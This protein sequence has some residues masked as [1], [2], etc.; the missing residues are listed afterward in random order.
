MMNFAIIKNNVVLNVIDATHRNAQLIAQT[1]EGASFFNVDGLPVQSGDDYIDGEFYRG[2]LNITG[3]IKASRFL[4][5]ND[6][7][8]GGRGL[9]DLIDVLVAKGVILD[10]DVPEALRNRIAERKAKRA[11]L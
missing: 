11:V 7:V 5:S 3:P 8:T 2:G 6:A 10:T 1:I 9:E 4:E